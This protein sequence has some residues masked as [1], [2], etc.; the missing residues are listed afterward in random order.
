[1]CKHWSP[2]DDGTRLIAYTVCATHLHV[3]KHLVVLA[4]DE[5]HARD[6]FTAYL[7]SPAQQAEEEEQCRDPRR[8]DEYRF[9]FHVGLITDRCADLQLWDGTPSTKVQMF[10]HGC[11]G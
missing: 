9:R 11:H 8:R 2:D 3:W 4:R 10:D 5:V 7:A 1:M 6:L